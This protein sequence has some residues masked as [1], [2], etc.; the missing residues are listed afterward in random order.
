MIEPLAA[1]IASGQYAASELREA[2]N[3]MSLLAQWDSLRPSEKARESDKGSASRFAFVPGFQPAWC[4]VCL[5]EVFPDY[6]DDPDGHCPT[7]DHYIGELKG[8]A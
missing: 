7:G 6:R 4:G 2:E 3:M 1:Q 5:E 8:A